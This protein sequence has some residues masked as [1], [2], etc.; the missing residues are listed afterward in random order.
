M[1]KPLTAFTL[2]VIKH[3]SGF[4]RKPSLSIFLLLHTS[5]TEAREQQEVSPFA[6]FA[7][8]GAPSV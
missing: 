3:V 4:L 2:L 7:L 6:F 8:A 5:H 1:D